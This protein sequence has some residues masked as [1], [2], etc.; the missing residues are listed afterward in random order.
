M[1]TVV[2]YRDK[3]QNFYINGFYIDNLVL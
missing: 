1:V 3:Q 2:E